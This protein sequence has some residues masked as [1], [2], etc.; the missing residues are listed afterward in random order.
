MIEAMRRAP[1]GKCGEDG[2]GDVVARS[3]HLDDD[4]K[5][6]RECRT[7]KFELGTHFGTISPN[8]PWDVEMRS[9]DDWFLR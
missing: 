6:K 9:S 4:A 7:G 5:K 3:G 8:I 1:P 2:E